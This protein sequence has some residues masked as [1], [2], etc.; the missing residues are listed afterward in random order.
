VTVVE[1]VSKKQAFSERH[2]GMQL[3]HLCRRNRCHPMKK[4]CFLGSFRS[5]NMA[6]RRSLQRR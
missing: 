6:R 4:L 1:V 3:F 5:A 2:D